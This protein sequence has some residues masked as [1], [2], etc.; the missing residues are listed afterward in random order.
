VVV[1]ARLVGDDGA[2]GCD[3][4]IDPTLYG[5]L[6]RLADDEDRHAALFQCP[7]CSALYEIFP[8]LKAIPPEVTPEEAR[9][10]FPGAI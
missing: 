2:V 6:N 3:R 7:K 4:C 8:E 1:A 5:Q 9:A 10:R